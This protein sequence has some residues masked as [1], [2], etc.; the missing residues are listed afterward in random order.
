L[1]LDDALVLSHQVTSASVSD[2]LALRRGHRAHVIG[3]QSARAGTVTAGF[4]ATIRFSPRRGDLPVHDLVEAAQRALAD[5]PAGAVLVIAAPDAPTEA[6]AG[7]KK[8]AAIEELGAAGVIAWGA[9]RDRGEA[10]AYEM[11]VWALGDTPRASGDLLQVLDVGV[12][13]SFGGVTVVP[14]DWVHVDESGLVVVPAADRD[15]VL[16]DALA[17]EAADAAAVEEI[18][19]RG[20]ENRAF[21]P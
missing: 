7:G 20:R 6:V 2:A 15:A 16:T 8:L 9:I 14:G 3:L 13:V 12:T 5:V 1:N 11:G 4:A 10:A 18:R 19:R 17:I 21:W